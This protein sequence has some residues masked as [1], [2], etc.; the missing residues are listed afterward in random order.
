MTTPGPFDDQAVALLRALS[1][2]DGIQASLDAAATP[3]Y[4]AVFTRDAVMAGVAGLLLDDP[5]ITTSFVRTLEH[6]RDLQGAEGQIPSTPSGRSRGPR[7]RCRL[8]W[9]SPR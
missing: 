6:L 1:G 2:P 9:R 8:T 5:T 4:R 7:W 3:N